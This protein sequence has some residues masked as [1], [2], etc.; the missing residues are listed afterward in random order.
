M[1]QRASVRKLILNCSQPSANTEVSQNEQAEDG[2][3]CKEK[4]RDSER[5]L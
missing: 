1:P 5:A 2:N 4:L 3:E